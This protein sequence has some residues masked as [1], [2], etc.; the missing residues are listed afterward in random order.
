ME[1]PREGR[2][3]TSIALPLASPDARRLLRQGLAP[4]QVMARRHCPN[5]PKEPTAIIAMLKAIYWSQVPMALSA[6]LFVWTCAALTGRSLNGWWYVAA[7]LGTWAVYLW[8][9]GSRLTREDRINQPERAT[10]FREYPLF[11]HAVP[12]LL[13]VPTLLSVWAA[14]PSL[15]TDVVLIAM[16]V[17]SAAYV[18]RIIPVAQTRRRLK[19]IG[20]I[21]TYLI[22]LAW[23]FG[24][25]FLPLSAGMRTEAG[26]AAPMWAICSFFCLLLFFDTLALDYRDRK[27]DRAAGLLTPAVQIGEE[28]WYFLVGGML[29][30]LFIWWV[31]IRESGDPRWIIG[32][33]AMWF[34]AF[35][36]I[37]ACRFMM[38][39]NA[40]YGSAIMFW[41]FAGAVGVA[42][43][44]I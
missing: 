21:K 19:E 43:A 10:F 38:G 14:G 22:T 32:G 25:I 18:L 40:L 28:T 12:L 1:P 9:A 15:R 16:I 35:T 8:D 23:L 20:T 7:F 34:S 5:S 11:R 41:R 2:Y 24:G 44:L 27:G 29:F 37:A 6:A 4:V 33:G 42:L 13:V 30:C 3:L 36:A 17:I 26:A 31:G 39:R